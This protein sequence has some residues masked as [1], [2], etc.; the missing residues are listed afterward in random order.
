VKS[1]DVIGNLTELIDDY[2]RIGEA[3]WPRFNAPTEKI[4]DNARRVISA[5]LE[6]WLGNPLGRRSPRNRAAIEEPRA[7]GVTRRELMGFELPR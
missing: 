6:R 2:E 5:I 4:L 1:A 3:V 7:S